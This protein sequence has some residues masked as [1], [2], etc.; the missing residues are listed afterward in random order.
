M[1][2]NE[3]TMLLKL[4]LNLGVNKKF[5]QIM[6]FFNLKMYYKQKTYSK[7]KSSI[8]FENKLDQEIIYNALKSKTKTKFGM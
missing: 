7:E 3:Q 6:Q 2:E 8:K 1:Q 5:S 4:L